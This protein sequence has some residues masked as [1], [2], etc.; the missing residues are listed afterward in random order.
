MEG[1]RVV[2]A[3]PLTCGVRP[4]TTTVSPAARNRPATALPSPDPPPVT[5]TMRLTKRPP[6]L[7]V[8]LTD[9]GH[10]LIEATV[11]RLLEHEAGLIDGLT[12]T[13]RTTLTGLLARLEATLRARTPP[14][15]GDG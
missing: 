6:Q 3:P 15:E 13:E 1:H 9:T 5:S 7:A 4:V 10:T 14:S 11:R 12:S 8:K 2:W